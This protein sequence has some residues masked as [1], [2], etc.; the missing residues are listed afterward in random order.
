MFCTDF[1]RPSPKDI[2]FW[3]GFQGV[4]GSA[5]LGVGSGYFAHVLEIGR[6]GVEWSLLVS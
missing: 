5:W 1:W 4:C 3:G 2:V 6:S